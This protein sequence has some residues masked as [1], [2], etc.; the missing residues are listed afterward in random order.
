M[1]TAGKD[2]RFAN[3]LSDVPR[4]LVLIGGILCR[5]G[6]GPEVFHLHRTTLERVVLK[7]NL[8]RVS[9]DADAGALFSF[10]TVLEIHLGDLDLLGLSLHIDADAGFVLAGVS[11]RAA[12]DPVAVSAPKGGAFVPEKDCCRGV[13]LQRAGKDD[14]IGIPVPNA[15]AVVVLR[16]RAILR[17]AIGHPPTEEE[18]QMVAR[19]CTVAEYRPLGPAARMKPEVRVVDGSAALE[20]DV[21]ADLEAEPIPVVFAGH[22]CP[23][24]DISYSGGTLCLKSKSAVITSLCNRLAMA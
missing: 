20:L 3:A 9:A 6:R 22:R 15:D 5:F 4:F 17:Q 1:D 10:G 11:N 14:I 12:L 16:K 18:S 7:L 21:V 23:Y 2:L 19:G 8:P 24:L 13:A